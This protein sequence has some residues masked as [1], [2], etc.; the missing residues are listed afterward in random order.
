LFFIVLSIAFH[1]FCSGGFSLAGARPCIAN[2]TDFPLQIAC[3]FSK[4]FFP[5]GR[6]SACAEPSFDELMEN[7]P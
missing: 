2:G 6:G 3:I 7:P 1:C 5:V 4:K